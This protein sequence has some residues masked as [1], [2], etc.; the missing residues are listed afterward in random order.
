VYRLNV[1]RHTPEGFSIDLLPMGM[2][3]IIKNI[4]QEAKI[5]NPSFS[6]LKTHFPVLVAVICNTGP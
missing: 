3:Q 2:S 4:S 5:S 6:Y 1:I